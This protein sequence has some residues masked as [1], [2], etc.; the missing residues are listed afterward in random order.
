M[1]VL[2]VV[3]ARCHTHLRGISIRPPDWRVTS[4]LR[5]LDPGLE[6]LVTSLGDEALALDAT[7]LLVAA[8][9]GVLPAAGV[10]LRLDATIE[11]LVRPGRFDAHA[12]KVAA[13]FDVTLDKARM[14]VGWIDEPTRWEPSP[15][16]HVQ[17]VHLPPGP[18]WSAADCGLVRLPAGSFFPWHIHEGGDEVTLVLQGRARYAGGIELGPGDQLVATPGTIHDFVVAEG[19]EYVFAVRFFAIRPVPPPI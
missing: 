3:H 17:L 2:D 9:P 7:T 12:A 1:L 19:D 5:S 18:A 4:G 8:L 15:L 11:T 14:F 6:A 10:R 13:L 16:P